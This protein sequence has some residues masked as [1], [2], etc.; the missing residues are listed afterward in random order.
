MITEFDDYCIHQTTNP[1][2]HPVDT[3]RNFYDRYWFDGA[4]RNGDFLFEIGLGVYPNRHVMDGHFSVS[5]DGKQHAFHSSCRAPANRNRTRIGPLSLEIIKPMR[6]LRFHIAPNDTGVECDL[7]FHASNAPTEE[8]KNQWSEGTRTTMINSRFT[9]FG[10][11]GGYFSVGGNKVEFSHGDT[12]GIRDKS[13]GVRPV[14]EPEVGAPAPEGGRV[15]VYWIWNPIDFGDVCTQFGS[16]ENEDGTPTQLSACLAPVYHNMDDIPDVGEPGLEEMHNISHNVVWEP[17]TRNPKS[18]AT[19]MTGSDGQTYDIELECGQ[20]FLM[21]GIGYSHPKWA[22]GLWHDELA[23]EYEVW[24]QA[25]EDP[26]AL[27]N[28]HTHHLVTAKM[29]QRV[30][31]GILETI[32]LGPHERSNFKDFLDGA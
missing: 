18:M 8:P 6:A 15:G 23:T 4:A 14:G 22:H 27:E 25:D 20:R 28:I 5:I 31:T 12:V 2:A 24:N 10:S 19:S 1:I 16:F 21:K 26:L 13:W 32:A 11:W 17:G 7:I 29:G 3:S 30:G 9:Q